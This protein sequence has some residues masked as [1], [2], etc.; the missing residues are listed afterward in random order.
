MWY[1]PPCVVH[2]TFFGVDFDRNFGPH[3]PSIDVRGSVA[4]CVC[5]DVIDGPGGKPTVEGPT[6]GVISV[7]SRLLRV[8]VL[9]DD[10]GGVICF[11]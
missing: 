7:L 3:L 1:V 2:R 4:W 10:E 5:G 11:V 9:A 8:A 6:C